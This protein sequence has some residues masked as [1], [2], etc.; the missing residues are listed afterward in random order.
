VNV[1]AL[2]GGV[3]GAKLLVGL[4]RALDGGRDL[5]AVVNTGDD[6]T[7]YGLHVSPD[8]DI[9]SYWLAGRADYERGWGLA[10][11]TFHVVDA[12]GRLGGESWFRLG[13]RDMAT[14]I[15]RTDRIKSGATLSAVTD[16]IRRG[17]GVAAR[18]LPMSDDAV[19]TTI[20]C[21]DGRTLEF[22]EWFVRERC[23]P[24]VAQV[25]FSGLPDAKPAPGF[26]D[27]LEEAE[28][29]MVCPSNPIVSIGPIVSLPG[30]RGALRAH[31]RVIAISPLID[32]V[33]LKGPADKLLAASGEEVSAAGVARMYADFCDMFVIDSRD[34]TSET[35]IEALGIR[36][37]RLDTVMTDHGL[38]EQL[39]RTLLAS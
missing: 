19:R 36:C 31:P 28:V 20:E 35:A 11:D 27:A 9:V 10:N 18:V 21:A 26:I 12:L 34:A 15:Y 24:T 16:E 14:C 37:L 39:A 33:P 5:T 30:V 25:R 29:V 32:G 1:A 6:T 8:V 3:G 13:D 17:L 22:Q 38:S 2:A 4:A 7:I 23:E